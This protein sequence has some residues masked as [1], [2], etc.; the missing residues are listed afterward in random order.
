VIDLGQFNVKKTVVKLTKIP[1]S[2]CEHLGSA[3]LDL[4]FWQVCSH[5]DSTE[6]FA[7]GRCLDLAEEDTPEWCPRLLTGRKK[8]E[9][10]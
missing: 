2:T 9:R 10:L 5:Q 4:D 7:G 1:C 3:K 6:M 8:T